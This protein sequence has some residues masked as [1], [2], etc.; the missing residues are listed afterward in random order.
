MMSAAN[1][2]KVADWSKSNNNNYVVKFSKTVV[3]GS[4]FKR[5]KYPKTSKVVV[6]SLKMHKIYLKKF[7]KA[8]AE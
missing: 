4:S 2:A 3:C 7:E 5:K 6:G 1:V 8:E